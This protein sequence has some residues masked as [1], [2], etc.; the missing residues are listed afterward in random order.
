MNLSMKNFIIFR[1]LIYNR[2][3]L[4]FESKKIYFIK[5]RIAARMEALGLE[6]IEDYIRQLKFRDPKGMEFQKFL[7]LLTTNETYM[8]RE[9]EQLAVFAE[10]CLDEICV[11]KK[12]NGDQKIRIWC[13]GCSTG[14]EPYTLAIILSEMLEPLRAWDVKIV[15]TDIDTKVLSTAKKGEYSLRSVKDVPDEYLEEY[16]QLKDGNF[17]VKKSIKKMV[18]FQHLNLMNMKEMK[19]AGQ[20]DFIFCRNVLI[21]FDDASRKEVVNQFYEHLN[22]NGFIFLGHSESISRI[23]SSFTLRKI[24]HLLKTVKKKSYF[25]LM[26]QKWCA[27]FIHISLK[28]PV[29]KSY[30]PLMGQTPLKNY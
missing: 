19:A 14:E 27:I 20:F 12:K 22:Q 21:Y 28:M 26:I 30:P 1:G 8:F 15:A 4:Y 18:T 6:K 3:G 10:K 29:L 11:R 9:F 24:L 16:L 13:A 23:S 2:C 7:N 5:K 25:L 17:V